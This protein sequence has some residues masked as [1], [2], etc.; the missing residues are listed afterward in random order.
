[1]AQESDAADGPP[2]A[3]PKGGLAADAPS[4]PRA[5]SSGVGE[6]DRMIADFVRVASQAR[7]AHELEDDVPKARIDL[8]VE[9]N[10]LAMHDMGY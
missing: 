9:L 6:V 2:P 1:M 3:D 7:K 8:L 10:R 4:P 5:A